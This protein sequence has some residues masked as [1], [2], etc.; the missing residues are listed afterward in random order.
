MKLRYTSDCYLG[1]NIEF[2]FRTLVVAHGE[3]NGTDYIYA[4]YTDEDKCPPGTVPDDFKER[5]EFAFNN[6]PV[7]K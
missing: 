3:I 4:E 2:L 5:A 6:T 1:P 7:P